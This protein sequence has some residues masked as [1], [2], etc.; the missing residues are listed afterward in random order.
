VTLYLKLYRRDVCF[1]DFCEHPNI[2]RKN[3]GITIS[4][5]LNANVSLKHRCKINV[6]RLWVYLKSRLF[7]YINVHYLNNEIICMVD[8]KCFSIFVL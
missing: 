8:H 4:N 1:D 7:M 3:P 6:I 5:Q 2:Q